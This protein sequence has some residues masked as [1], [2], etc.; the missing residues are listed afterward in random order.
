MI[1]LTEL[2]ILETRDPVLLAV[3]DGPDLLA[4][5]DVPAAVPAAVPAVLVFVS[6]G[7]M[8]SLSRTAKLKQQ[9][10]RMRSHS[11]AAAVELSHQLYC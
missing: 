1:P 6:A 8:N 9:S 11:T 5:P 2:K 10:P 3:P 4:E 7:G